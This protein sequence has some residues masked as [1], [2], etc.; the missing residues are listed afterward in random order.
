MWDGGCKGFLLKRGVFYGGIGVETAN[1]L[2]LPSTSGVRIVFGTSTGEGCRDESA[3]EA[4]GRS[5]ESPSS[6]SSRVRVEGMRLGL[7]LTVVR[8]PL[9]AGEETRLE[10]TVSDVWVVLVEE[11]EGTVPRAEVVGECESMMTSRNALW[12][13]GVLGW[14]SI[15]VFPRR[16]GTM[17]G[18][19]NKDGTT[20]ARAGCCCLARSSLP[21]SLS[22]VLIPPRA[23]Q[24]FPIFH[25]CSQ[26][27]L[28]QLYRMRSSLSS[29]LQTISQLNVPQD[30]YQ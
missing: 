25:L 14:A 11:V 8:A 1:S 16:F 2:S 5:S 23:L 7:E 20:G 12:T 17:S 9:V 24:A 28:P 3:K 30:S 26:P 15:R 22:G 19:K 27:P 18:V 10:G 29:Q 13:V 21:P 6:S 4:E